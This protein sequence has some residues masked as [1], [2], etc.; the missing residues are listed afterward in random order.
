MAAFH[1]KVFLRAS[2]GNFLVSFERCL[3]LSKRRANAKF[4]AGAYQ[5]K[6]ERLDALDVQH[7]HLISICRVLQSP[8]DFTST[9]TSVS[10]AK[11][12]V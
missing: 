4:F 3:G 1:A 10:T 8:K 6:M 12:D 2:T 9:N 11:G 7:A 5:Y